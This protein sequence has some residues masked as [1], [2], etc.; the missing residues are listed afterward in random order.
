MYNVFYFII[1]YYSLQK[2]KKDRITSSIKSK[3]VVAP[4]KKQSK[5]DPKTRRV[6][7]TPGKRIH[8]PNYDEVDKTALR[9]MSKLRVD[10][11]EEEDHTLLSCKLAILYLNPPQGCGVAFQA[12]RDILH[13]K[14]PTCI[15]KT[16]KA[17]QRRI[18]YILKIN[19]ETRNVLNFCVEELKQNVDIEEKYGENFIQI[20]RQ[21]YK[22]E[23][24]FSVALKIHFV[25]LVYL[26]ENCY[27]N[28]ATNQFMY[29]NIILPD[30]VREFQDHF[31]MLHF[32]ERVFAENP[33]SIEGIQIM[34]ID[35]V[36]HS[37]MCCMK[38]KTTWN[39]QLFDIYKNY[40][41]ELLRQSINTLRRR[42]VI[43]ANKSVKTKRL[44]EMPV[45]GC[46]FHLSQNY[47]NQITTKVSYDAF[48]EAFGRFLELGHEAATS[49]TGRYFFFGS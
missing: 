42:Q 18:N 44:L 34:M 40:P 9:L 30:T 24:D 48:S 5:K 21:V 26:L 27:K 47:L 14:H 46:P 17:C 22:A 31:N 43:S 3:T 10:W 13:F 37:S 33:T 6:R 25:L 38:D 15:N 45:S 29:K 20:L 4:R 41:D 39:L 16:T 8:L 19:A 11:K 2:L 7:I 28:L 35:T 23:K 36:I 12:V 32:N 49:E 1:F